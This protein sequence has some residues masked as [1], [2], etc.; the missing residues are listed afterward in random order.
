MLQAPSID[1]PS[2]HFF[3]FLSN[4]QFTSIST[5]LHIGE[6]DI[7]DHPELGWSFSWSATPA[8]SA[9]AERQADERTL[10]RPGCRRLPAPGDKRTRDGRRGSAKAWRMM[11]DDDDWQS[12]AVS[13]T[14]ST[15]IGL[16]KGR[17]SWF[18]SDVPNGFIYA[19]WLSWK[20]AKAR[21]WRVRC[22]GSED[23]FFF[24]A[25]E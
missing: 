15:L 14:L 13:G 12:A 25:E 18:Q 23:S 16:A 1:S 10:Q 20:S 7:T 19:D 9:C 22:S 6:M 11:M 24:F 17:G 3:F 8:A 21:I 4:Q 5:T 2:L